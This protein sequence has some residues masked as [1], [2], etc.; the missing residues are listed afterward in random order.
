M[1]SGVAWLQIL[2]LLLTF[3]AV[4]GKCLILLSLSFLIYKIVIILFLIDS[5]MHYFHILTSLYASHNCH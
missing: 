2:T 4:L 5:K 3:S 1:G